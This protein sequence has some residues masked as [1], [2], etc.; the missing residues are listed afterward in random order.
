MPRL[1]CIA[2][3][4]E[5]VTECR[6][7]SKWE[8]IERSVDMGSRWYFY[9][10]HFVVSDSGLTVVDAPDEYKDLVRKRLKTVKRLFKEEKVPL[11]W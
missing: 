2:A 1:V 8:C 7:L 5:H 6:D 4:G 11:F 3:D 9:P 10:Y